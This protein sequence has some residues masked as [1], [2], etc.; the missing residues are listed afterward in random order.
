M[1]S[2]SLRFDGLE[3]IPLQVW[4]AYSAFEATG[5]FGMIAEGQRHF[6][7]IHMLELVAKGQG[8]KFKSP[9]KFKDLNP[10]AELIPDLVPSSEYDDLADEDDDGG[11]G[12][13]LLGALEKR[14][15]NKG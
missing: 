2:G 8:T 4:L 5:A 6:V 13:R 7:L 9:L 14:N 3:S 1:R 15:A 12:R 11:F 10:W